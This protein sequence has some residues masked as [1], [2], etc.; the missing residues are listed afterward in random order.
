M[1]RRGQFS[2]IPDILDICLK[3]HEVS[4]YRD[5]SLDKEAMRRVARQAMM[6]SSTVKAGNVICFVHETDDVVDGIFVGQVTRLYECLD[7]L[8]AQDFL[9]YVDPKSHPR[10]AKRLLEAFENWAFS[11]DNSVIVRI[12]V[13]DAI[14]RSD[15][16]AIWLSRQGYRHCGYAFEKEKQT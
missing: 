11:S 4:R 16:T 5:V 2:D 14:V 3:A 8:L 9:F 12:V 1:V 6:N 13:T 10:A 15:Y 7:V